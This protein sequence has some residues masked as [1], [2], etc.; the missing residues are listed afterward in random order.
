MPLR[1]C[2]NAARRSRP[3]C[4]RYPRPR[5]RNHTPALLHQLQDGHRQERLARRG[6]VERD[7]FVVA[8]LPFPVGHAVAARQHRPAPVR[9]Q[10]HARE[11]VLCGQVRH[12]PVIRSAGPSVRRDPVVPGRLG[13]SDDGA[14]AGPGGDAGQHRSDG[15]RRGTERAEHAPPPPPRAGSGLIR[16]IRVVHAGLLVFIVGHASQRRHVGRVGPADRLP[17]T[18]AAHLTSGVVAGSSAERG[19][20]PLGTSA[21][22]TRRHPR[23]TDVP[24]RCRG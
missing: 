23:V 15:H 13:R 6:E 11:L 8:D 10:H 14:G 5:C 3:G 22:R 19:N 1:S 4:T 21:L 2:S 17:T 9:Q 12:V 18:P 20:D 7:V 24:R 16:L